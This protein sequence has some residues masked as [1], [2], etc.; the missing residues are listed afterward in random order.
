MIE[1]IV[2]FTGRYILGMPVMYTRELTQALTSVRW[3]S[4]C[5]MLFSLC[6]SV[7]MV[8]VNL[9][10]SLCNSSTLAC[11]LH[12]AAVQD[13]YNTGATQPMVDLKYQHQKNPQ[14][15]DIKFMNA[16][17]NITK[18]VWSCICVTVEPVLS[19]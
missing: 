13:H 10:T 3:R 5:F 1:Y 14:R 15:V 16:K 18:W 12:R 8:A 19:I 2:Y 4:L 9:S 11:R 6:S 17:V 7:V